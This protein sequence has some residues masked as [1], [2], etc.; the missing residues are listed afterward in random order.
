MQRDLCL[1]A[2]Y[3]MIDQKIALYTSSAEPICPNAL[4]THGYSPRAYALHQQYVCD[5]LVL[6]T[7]LR[8]LTA[9]KSIWPMSEQVCDELSWDTLLNHVR[10]IEITTA[11]GNIV[12]GSDTHEVLPTMLSEIDD[13]TEVTEGLKLAKWV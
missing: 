1:Q 4:N 13:L 9:N 8:G 11:C 6:G 7:L 5:A 12:Y 10:N 3:A 2:I